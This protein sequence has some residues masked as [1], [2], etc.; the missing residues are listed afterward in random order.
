[1]GADLTCIMTSLTS[2]SIITVTITLTAV[3]RA[4]ITVSTW[5]IGAALMMMMILPRPSTRALGGDRSL[6]AAWMRSIAQEASTTLTSSTIRMRAGQYAGRLTIKVVVHVITQTG[7]SSHSCGLLSQAC[8]RSGIDF[9]NQD[10]LDAGIAF[11]LA[12]TDPWGASSTG[13]TI[14]PN[15]EWWTQTKTQAVQTGGFKRETQWDPDRFFNVWTLNPPG[16][17][18]GTTLLGYAYMPYQSAGNIVDGVVM[19]W[20][21]TGATAAKT[22]ERL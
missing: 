16:S 17:R 11:E 1:M 22:L 10:F 7:C 21:L 4:T 13:I 20:R 18:P 19:R 2:T 6:I 12:D 15:S 5:I 14:H 9:L 3:C 8:I